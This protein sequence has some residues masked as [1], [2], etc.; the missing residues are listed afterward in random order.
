VIEFNFGEHF[1]HFKRGIHIAKGGG[2]NEVMATLGQIPD[3]TFSFR[4]FGHTVD[5]FGFDLVAKVLFQFKSALVVLVG[6]AGITNRA[7]INK[8]NFEL[9]CSHG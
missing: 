3:H 7:D 8:A 5:K 4:A 6:P 2:E 1:G 9:I